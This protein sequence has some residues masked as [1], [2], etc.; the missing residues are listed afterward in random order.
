MII[1]AIA[2]YFFLGIVR[3]F[4][5]IMPRLSVDLSKQGMKSG[6]HSYVPWRDKNLEPDEPAGL[7]TIPLGE[8][9]LL[10]LLPVWKPR[11]GLGIS[12]YLGISG[13][14]KLWRHFGLFGHLHFRKIDILCVANW[15][16]WYQLNTLLLAGW[17]WRSN[18]KS[19]TKCQAGLIPNRSLWNMSM[20]PSTEAVADGVSLETLGGVWG[21]WLWGRHVVGAAL[22]L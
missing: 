10:F 17:S 2:S 16:I 22:V 21:R 13:P 6:I 4:V 14:Q 18:S 11:K 1:A 7:R 19:Q 3:F 20:C 15:Q 5:S 9:F 8:C 12:A